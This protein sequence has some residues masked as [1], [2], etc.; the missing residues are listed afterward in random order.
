VT[1]PEPFTWGAY[2][3]YL[4][5]ALDNGYRFVGFDAAGSDGE[6]PADSIF[7]RHDIDFSPVWVEPMAEV[8]SGVGVRSTYCFQPDSWLYEIDSDQSKAAVRAALRL[9][10]W[11]GVHVDAT[12]VDS[13]AEVVEKVLAQR[14]L[15]EDRFG[16]EVKAVSFHMPERRDI[17]HI[18]LPEG[19]VN[20]YAQPFLDEVGY[21][22]D[23]NQDWRGQDL[24]ELLTT[25][26]HSSL[27]I[28]IHPMW[29]RKTHS[30][31]IEKLRELAEARGIELESLVTY[32]QRA[33]LGSEG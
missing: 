23:S 26:A 8:E 22:S 28:L 12:E 14:S 20:T 25:R 16:A 3:R 30:P 13:D 27:Q 21:V 9:G 7:L 10:H 19:L 5:L 4:R 31:M 11:L 1:A 32:E 6:P 17:E 18:E 15:L 24:E 29:W 33:L 2:E